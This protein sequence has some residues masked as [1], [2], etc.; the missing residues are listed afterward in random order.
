M[1]VLGCVYV[2]VCC[3]VHVSVDVGVFRCVYCSVCLC[4]VGL[5]PKVSLHTPLLEEPRLTQ[6]WTSLTNAHVP[7]VI[8]GCP[9]RMARGVGG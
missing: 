7:S 9:G 2:S 8:S 5:Y 6:V 4:V 3:K 1:P